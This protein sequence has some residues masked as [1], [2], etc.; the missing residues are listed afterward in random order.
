M[1]FFRDAVVLGCWTFAVVTTLYG[2][3]ASF[4]EWVPPYLLFVGPVTGVLLGVSTVRPLRYAW[5]VVLGFAL[6]PIVA[7][8]LNT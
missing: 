7:F 8:L 5:I 1:G 2:F 4:G 3:Y 6:F